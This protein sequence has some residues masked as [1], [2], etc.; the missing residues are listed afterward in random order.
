MGF[1]AGSTHPAYDRNRARLAVRCTGRQTFKIIPT[2]ARPKA[3]VVAHHL[4]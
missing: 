1:A 2:A 4:L 3:G